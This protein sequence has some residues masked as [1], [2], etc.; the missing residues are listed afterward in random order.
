MKIKIDVF[1]LKKWYK[2][3]LDENFYK[4]LISLGLLASAP[5]IASVLFDYIVIYGNGRFKAGLLLGI[6][7]LLL[8][9]LL[10]FISI[11]IWAAINSNTTGQRRMML[12]ISAYLM[13]WL[14]FGNLY[15]FFSDTENF[16]ATNAAAYC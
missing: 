13:I 11:A 15:Y 4:F 8:F 9:L 7:L 5:V 10:S 12:I 6:V 14:A 3:L 2:Q 16:V 1:G